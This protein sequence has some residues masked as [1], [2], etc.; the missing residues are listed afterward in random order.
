MSF[1]DDISVVQNLVLE[2]FWSVYH[3][4]LV[5]PF[6][7]SATEAHSWQWAEKKRILARSGYNW[8]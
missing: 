7:E 4:M 1:H 2:L 8:C 3:K 5:L 6:R